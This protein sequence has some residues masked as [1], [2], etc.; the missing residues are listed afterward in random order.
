LDAAA[1]RIG[2][3]LRV[4]LRDKDPLGEIARH[5]SARGDGDV[6]LVL[7]TSSGEVEVKLPGKFSVSPQVAGALKAIPGIVAVE[8]L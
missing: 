7:L 1:S 2:T 3:G 8:H 4:F 6:S 5:L